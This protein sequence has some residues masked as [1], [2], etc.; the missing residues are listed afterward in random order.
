M[1]QVRRTDRAVLVRVV[2]RLRSGS[3][4]GEK[5]CGGVIGPCVDL[6]FGG[7]RVGAEQHGVVEWFG[8]DEPIEISG[9]ESRVLD[10]EDSPFVKADEYFC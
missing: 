9:S 3:V 4:C 6:S 10:V 5:G 8:H 2:A 1:G 7:W